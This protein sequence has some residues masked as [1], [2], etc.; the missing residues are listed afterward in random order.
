MLCELVEDRG[1]DTVISE[2]CSSRELTGNVA[3]EE[4]E[5]SLTPIDE[6]ATE[7]SWECVIL[8]P[9]SVSRCPALSSRDPLALQSLQKK[10][11]PETS[12]NCRR[13]TNSTVSVRIADEADPTRGKFASESDLE[14][15]SA[16]NDQVWSFSFSLIHC[17]PA[18]STLRSLLNTKS[19]AKIEQA[20]RNSCELLRQRK[21]LH[22]SS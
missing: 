1:R 8:M 21:E 16:T 7:L 6:A 4:L 15:E 10:S 5:S 18:M 13:L 3:A 2:A 19:C 20:L 11:L 22:T 9:C 17:P 12:I 14:F